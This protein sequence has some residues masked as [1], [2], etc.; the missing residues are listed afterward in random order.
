MTNEWI[1]SQLF[2]KHLC[3]LQLTDIISGSNNG[4]LEQL[5]SVLSKAME[6]I[7]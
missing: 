3:S 6:L 1:N 7:Q 5:K 4:L 2:L